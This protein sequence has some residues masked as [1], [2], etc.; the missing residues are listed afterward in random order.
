MSVD[1]EA[2]RSGVQ[3][4]LRQKGRCVLTYVL[5]HGAA[6]LAIS[7]TVG[8]EDS[9]LQ[10]MEL[11]AGLLVFIGGPSLL[12]ALVATSEHRRMDMVQFRVLLG[13]FLIL[14]AWPLV[15]CSTPEPLLFQVT[16]QIAFA[17]LVPTPL[18]PEH[19]TGQTGQ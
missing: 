8:W 9:F 13:M 4:E 17:A 7:Q 16:A 10:T 14:C 6:W 12:V 5:L 18:L 3:S 2:V 15:G 11:G 19:S 1:E